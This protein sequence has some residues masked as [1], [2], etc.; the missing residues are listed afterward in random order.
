MTKK[1]SANYLLS[2]STLLS[3]LLLFI[4]LTIW[5]IYADS[6]S[7][8]DEM[9]QIGV[10]IEMIRAHMQK[11]GNMHPDMDN[12][13]RQLKKKFSAGVSLKQCCQYCHADKVSSHGSL[14]PPSPRLSGASRG[15]GEDER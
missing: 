15:G 2:L 10:E 9:D 6:G 12:K 11:D 3:S 8:P 13:L 5:P 14:A 4:S 1:I 7:N